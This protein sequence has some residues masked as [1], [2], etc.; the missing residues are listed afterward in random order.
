MARHIGPLVAMAAAWSAYAVFTASQNF[1]SRAYGARIEW[2]QALAY[3]SLDSYSWLALTPFAFWL[4][5]RLVVRRANWW[6]TVPALFVAGVLLAAAHLFLLVQ[7]LPLIGYRVNQ[8]TIPTIVMSKLHA[9]V[10]TCWVLFGL[11][12][13]IE[14][15]NQYRIRELTASRLEARL[16]LAQ[17]QA[18]QMQL[19]PHFLFNTL[20]AVSAL[21]YR[22]VE[23]ADRML[24]RLS[25]FLRLTLDSAGVQEVPLKREMEYLDKYLDIEQV[26]FGDRL[27]IRQAIDSET[28]DLL[29]PNLVLQPLVEN[30][31]RYAV[32][33]RASGGSIEVSSRRDGDSLVIEVLDN[34]PGVAGAIREGIGLSNTRARLEQLYGGGQSL[35]AGNAAGGGFRV[36]LTIPARLEPLDA[37]PDR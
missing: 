27:Q 3:A 17:V 26:R 36:R 32:A 30:A 29:V 31:V 16:A 11:R 10:L 7:L 20:H 21:M 24:A 37:S 8:H 1:L 25:D 34:G 23:A 12:H 19:H 6:K 15:Y 28:L 18:L 2:K 4:A 9:D 5:G 13:A 35:D 14:Y 22:N 33:P